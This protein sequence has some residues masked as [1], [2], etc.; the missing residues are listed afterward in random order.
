MTSVS[1]LASR[2][3]ISRP[4]LMQ[5]IRGWGMSSAHVNTARS[6]ADRCLEYIY[7]KYRNRSPAMRMSPFLPVSQHG[8]EFDGLAAL[9]I[10]LADIELQDGVAS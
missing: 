9:F 7:R 5:A 2:V 6:I 4:H 1:R 3:D 10:R 8:I